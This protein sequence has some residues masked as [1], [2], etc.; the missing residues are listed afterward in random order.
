MTV[1]L[2]DLTSEQAM[3]RL[4]ARNTL[5]THIEQQLMMLK[6]L[7]GVSD[8]TVEETKERLMKESSK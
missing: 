2:K 5:I 7:A 8:E 4:W 3:V 6:I 1:D